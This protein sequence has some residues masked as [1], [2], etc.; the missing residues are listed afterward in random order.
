MTILH[1]PHLRLEP[2][3]DAHLMGLHA[4][5]REPEVMRYITGKPETLD[6]TRAAIARTQARWA[7]WGYGWWALI[8]Q[9]S[10]ALAG[11]ACL[12]H[13]GGERSNPHELGWRL[14]PA[15]WGK[16]YAIEAARRIAAH[17]FDDQRAPLLMA[18]RHPDNTASGRVMD[19]LGMT[20]RPLLERWY[21]M[22]CAV[23]EVTAATWAAALTTPPLR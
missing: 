7:T 19:K 9:D 17:A 4:M 1:T 2:F 18:V 8:E 5:N 6:D 22:D 3:A 23:H 21:D 20:Q 13:M 16:G 11:A 10:G 14:H 12:Q 15:H